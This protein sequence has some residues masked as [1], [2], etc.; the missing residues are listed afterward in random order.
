[1]VVTHLP[2]G[3]AGLGFSTVLKERPENR[4]LLSV[5]VSVLY[6]QIPPMLHPRNVQLVPFVFGQ[7]FLE[8]FCPCSVELSAHLADVQQENSLELSPVWPL[9]VVVEGFEEIELRY[10]VVVVGVKDVEGDLQEEGA[11]LDDR[12]YLC[13]VLC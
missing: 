4:L 3:C 5:E 6:L 13:L 9:V 7:A 2:G 12:L 11:L 8:A 1:M 10:F